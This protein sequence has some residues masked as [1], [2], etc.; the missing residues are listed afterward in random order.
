MTTEMSLS[1]Q[2]LS[3]YPSLTRAEKKMADY[4]LK[5]LNILNTQTLAQ[6]SKTV[7]VGEATIMRFIYKL[8]YKNLA[9]FKVAVIQENVVNSKSEDD[10]ES[11]EGCAKLIY[12][13][14]KDTIRANTNEDIDNVAKLI[15]NA[16][17]VYFFGNGT[18]GYSAEVAAYRFFRAGV[19]CE[20]ITDIHLMTMKSVLVKKEEL[21]IAVSQSGD[22]LDL[23]HAAKNVKKNHCPIVTITGRTHSFL[24]TLG[25]IS[26]IHAPLSLTDNSY[27]GG[28]L[29]II[30]QEF[31]LKLIFRAYSQRN[32]ERT[33]EMQRITTISTDLFHKTLYNGTPRTEDEDSFVLETGKK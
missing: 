14:L 6:M 7:H 10:D 30:I 17:H 21:V 4:I 23:I 1:S 8:G 3:A 16:S 2:I 31:I 9:Q 12:K 29:G 13:L 25:D 27:Y 24:S 32:F 19:S 20:G 18:S 26:L 11:A 15:E 33:D 5:H 22:N 28:T